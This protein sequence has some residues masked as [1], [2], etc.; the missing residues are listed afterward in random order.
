MRSNI[1]GY[2]LQGLREIDFN[3]IIQQVTKKVSKE[4]IKISQK[5][6]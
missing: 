2:T 5:E 4:I 3:K 1:N 6:D